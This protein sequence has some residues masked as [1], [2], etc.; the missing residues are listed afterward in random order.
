M[1]FYRVYFV[2]GFD[3]KIDVNATPA[4]LNTTLNTAGAGDFVLLGNINYSRKNICW[5]EPTV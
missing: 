1:A 4:Q 5:I 2:G 3:V